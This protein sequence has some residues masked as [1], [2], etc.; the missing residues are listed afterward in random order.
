M[1]KI[2]LVLA[3]LCSLIMFSQEHFL[4]IN[5]SRKTTMLNVDYNPAELVNLSNKVDIGILH[6]SVN[7][8]NNKI[9][10][11]DFIDSDKS[12]EDYE[13][14][15]LSGGDPF[16]TSVNFKLMGPSIGVRLKKWG[17]GFKYTLNANVSLT[18]LDP[19]LIDIIDAEEDFITEV[20]TND[21]QRITAVAYQ[22][23]DFS[24]ARNIMENE[25][26]KLSAGVTVK[27]LASE[28]YA[29]GGINKLNAHIEREEDDLYFS[30]AN[31]DVELTYSGIFNR[32]FDEYN[33]SFLANGIEGIGSDIG[34]NYQIK[35][36]NLKYPYK[37]NLGLAVKDIGSMNIK[38]NARKE[39]YKLNIPSNERFNTAE[40]NDIENAED[41][42]G[43]LEESNYFEST[44]SATSAKVKL[45][46]SLHIYAD[47]QIIGNFF[48]TL[49][50]NQ[51][52][53][54]NSNNDVIPNY[55]TYALI[56][57][58]SANGF[59]AYLPLSISSIS[60]FNAGFGLR[61]G[62]FF[63]LGS[64]SALSAMLQDEI[65]KIDLHLGLRFGIGSRK[66]N[67]LEEIEEPKTNS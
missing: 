30:K 18:N 9:N 39:T 60:K 57:R 46:T 24:V 8:S 7:A 56:P 15:L 51:S 14:A 55:S 59:E 13:A 26:A 62:G 22:T 67:S 10:M 27:L 49:Q 63:Y 42:M 23:L 47:Y 16:S 38:E 35:N 19:K 36:T 48:G 21:N 65:K 58:Y 28:A 12:S 25:K 33:Y 40:F 61:L 45:P 66:N 44:S 37:L 11:L 1:K 50:V 31:A 41:L 20:K 29:N 34:L 53:V 64:S 43:V 4:G 3:C 17:F 32:S 2:F 52:L 54:K 6:L 5:T